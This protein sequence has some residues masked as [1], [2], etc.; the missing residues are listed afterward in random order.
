M[1]V[2]DF[3]AMTAAMA[4]SLLQSDAIAARGPDS[5]P[6]IISIQKVTN[7]SSD[8]M[9]QREQWSIMAQIRGAAPIQTL[10]QQKNVRFVLPAQRVVELRNAGV[11]YEDF[12]AQR[13]PTHTMTATFRSATRAQEKDR[14][15]LYYT[16]FEIIDLQTGVPVWQD[17]FEFKRA[18]H[19]QIWD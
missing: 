10:W 8:V 11:E 19:G 1:T 18:A 14:T 16:E 9:P 4:Q 3:D 2:D 5:D 17:R 6:W 12:G 13:K 15:D 7:L